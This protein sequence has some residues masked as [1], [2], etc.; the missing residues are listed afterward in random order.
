MR[1][2]LHLGSSILVVSSQEQHKTTTTKYIYQYG[3]GFEL[4]KLCIP[5][6]LSKDI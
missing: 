6:D 1:T 4:G 3:L 5:K 2:Q